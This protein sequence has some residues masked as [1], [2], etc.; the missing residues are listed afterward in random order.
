M[1]RNRGKISDASAEVLIGPEVSPTTCNTRV[2]II[3]GNAGGGVTNVR[4]SVI[5]L[6]RPHSLKAARI[7]PLV[8]F[9]CA[10]A[11][12]ATRTKASAQRKM[13]VCLPAAAVL[14]PRSHLT[15]GVEFHCCATAICQTIIQVGQLYS[16]EA[17]SKRNYARTARLSRETSAL[18]QNLA[19]PE[20]GSSFARGWWGWREKW[21]T[22]FR[23]VPVGGSGC[24]LTHWE[25]CSYAMSNRRKVHPRAPIFRIFL[26]HKQQKYL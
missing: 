20:Q 7:H 25:L 23:P 15:S 2:L 22:L 4:W 21:A 17:A 9:L 10:F 14:T 3:A 24:T 19:P 1:E 18:R 6:T 26:R 11:F 12:A 8:F 5:G 16:Y 13:S